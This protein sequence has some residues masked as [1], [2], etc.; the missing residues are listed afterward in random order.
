MFAVVSESLSMETE[1]TNKK[2]KT[3]SQGT[4]EDAGDNKFVMDNTSDNTL[5]MEE[6]SQ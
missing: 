6:V 4:E 1:P 3:V 5:N 2:A